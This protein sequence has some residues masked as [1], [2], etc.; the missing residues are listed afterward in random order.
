VIDNR[1]HKSAHL[2]IVH[3]K[4]FCMKL[5]KK[6]SKTSITCHL[7]HLTRHN[8]I[9]SFM[10]FAIIC[11]VFPFFFTSCKKEPV[12][13]PPKEAPYEIEW[14]KTFGGSKLDNFSAFAPTSD[15]AYIVTGFTESNDGD[16]SGNHG[17]RDAW[18]FKIDRSGNILWTKALGGSDNDEGSSV[19]ANTDNTYLIAGNTNS[20]DGNV[21]ENNGNQDLWLVKLSSSGN[22]LWQKS[23]GGSGLEFIVFSSILTTSD[24]GY[25]VLG[26]TTS[27]DKNMSTN[28]GGI[29][30]WLLKLDSNGSIIW[31]KTFGGSQDDISMSIIASGDGGYLLTGQSFSNDG[32]VSGSHG[33]GD[34]WIVKVD[35]NGK[36]LWQKTLGGSG[37]DINFLPV[38]IPGG[39]YLVSGQTSSPND[40]DV[41]GFHGDH[42]AWV[43]KLDANGGVVW[44]KALGS[45]QFE[46]N[47]S[48]MNTTDG[49][50][51]V[52][53]FTNGNEG[54]VTGNHGGY[55]A[56]LVKLDNSGNIIWQK[57][58]GG[59]GADNPTNVLTTVSGGYIFGGQTTSNDGDVK[60]NH[61]NEDAWL[62]TVKGK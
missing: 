60:G 39:G 62:F 30:F 48:V 2:K 29:D 35:T 40:G 24:G 6:L 9:S 12:V 3:L 54:D 19:V 33:A 61:G 44:Q 25:M 31:Q 7:L 28:H 16:I 50:G 51:L 32:D 23:F 17:M 26:N 22:I 56:W 34:G 57:T 41:K 20:H 53:A 43:V 45:S 55:D 52:A 8:Q 14:S 18:A 59:S 37:F 4:K 1:L 13:N 42:D 21:T 5:I 27:N 11:L 58:Y 46:G 10:R 47:Y 38:A 15:G 36:K 49:G